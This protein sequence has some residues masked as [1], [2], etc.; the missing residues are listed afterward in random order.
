MKN[1]MRELKDQIDALIKSGHVKEAM[2]DAKKRSI[3][4]LSI[5]QREVQVVHIVSDCK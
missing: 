2:N 4:D 5:Y 3:S 1:T